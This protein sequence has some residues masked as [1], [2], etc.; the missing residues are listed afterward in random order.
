MV[1]HAILKLYHR[2]RGVFHRKTGVT[3]VKDGR[4]DPFHIAPHDIAHAV[5]AMDCLVN[6]G[7]SAF[8]FPGTL[9]VRAFIIGIGSVPGEKGR[10]RLYFPVNALFQSL[11]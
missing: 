4:F 8:V 11:L 10:S 9:P 5:N 2:F 6:D 3:P 7:S 1:L